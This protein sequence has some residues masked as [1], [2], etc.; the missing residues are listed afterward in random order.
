MSLEE[1]G[2]S[3]LKYCFFNFVNISEVRDPAGG[4][5]ATP[6]PSVVAGVCAGGV[7]T[8]GIAKLPHLAELQLTCI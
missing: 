2:V 6:V 5:V 8:L 4:V 3:P 1:S 7:L